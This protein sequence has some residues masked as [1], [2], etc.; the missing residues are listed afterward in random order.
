MGNEETVG[1][2]S[3]ERIALNQSTFRRANEKIELAADKMQL[4]GPVPFI[5]E[6]ADR[7]CTEIVRLSLDEYESVPTTPASSS[8]RPATKSSPSVPAPP[9][10]AHATTATSS[11]KRPGS[12]ARSQNRNT[13]T[14]STSPPAAPYTPADRRERRGSNCR[15]LPSATTAMSTGQL[16]PPHP[17]LAW[18][19]AGGGWSRTADSSAASPVRRRSRGS[20]PHRE[21]ARKDSPAA[22]RPACP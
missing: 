10:S 19:S 6:C 14:S 13:T 12:P 1:R 5:C 20:P 4:I 3:D 18:R 11:S 8:T 15:R 17:R 9:K 16:H 7:T 21:R 22:R 2:L